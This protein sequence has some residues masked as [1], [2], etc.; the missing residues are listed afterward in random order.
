MKRKKAGL[1][2]PLSSALCGQCQYIRGQRPA[3]S[4]CGLQVL[5]RALAI[6]VVL[7]DVEAELLALDEGAHAGPLDS[8]DV[9]EYVRLAIAEFDEAKA[10]GRI[11][12][13][14]SSSIHD[15]F[16]SIIH[17]KWLAAQDARQ[18]V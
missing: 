3:Q 2:R 1:A 17:R 14:D 11:E 10:F 15:D 13:L 12:E 16:L 9:D 18:T 5:G 8:G 7:H 4:L 6:T